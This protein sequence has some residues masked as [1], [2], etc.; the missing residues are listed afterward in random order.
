MALYYDIVYEFDYLTIAVPFLI[1][2]LIFYATYLVLFRSVSHRIRAK[3]L[4]AR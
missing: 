3:R 4:V 1:A 2:L